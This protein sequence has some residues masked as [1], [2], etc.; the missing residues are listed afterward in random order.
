MIDLDTEIT[1]L[2]WN[3][4]VAMMCNTKNARFDYVSVWKHRPSRFAENARVLT[5]ALRDTL[6]E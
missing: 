1:D 5:E 3:H 6:D 2:R 4:M